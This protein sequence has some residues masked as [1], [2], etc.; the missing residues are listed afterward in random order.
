MILKRERFLLGMLLL[1]LMPACR[2]GTA[3]REKEAA[4]A[5]STFELAPGFTMEMMAIEPLISDPVAMEIDEYGR[6]YVVEMHG[7]PLDKSG[8]GKVKLLSDTDGDGKM[9]KSVVF[10][11][12]LVLPTGVLR[13]QKGILV[14]DAPNVLYFEDTDGDGRSD[15]RDTLLRGFALSNPQHNVNNPVLGM[16]NWIYL[17]H[18]PAITSKM[19]T[20]EFGDTGSDIY[21]PGRVNSPKLPQ[22]ARGRSVRFRPDRGGLELLSSFTQFGQTFDPWGR[23]LLVHN[24]NHIYHE[25]IGF[26]YLNRNPD[27]LVS[28]ATQS[29]SDHGAAAEVY[30][31]T[32]NPEHQIY[33]DVGVFTSSCGLTY[34]SGGLFPAPFDSVSFVAEPVSNIV[35]A[36]LLRDKGASFTASRL[37]EN[38]EFLAST[39]SWFRPVNMYVGPDGALYILDYYRQIIEHPEWMEDEVVKSGALYN[40]MDKGRIYRITP[41][42]TSSAS[43]T[44]GFKLGD[45]SSEQLVEKLADPNGWYRRN[46]QRLLIDR[47]DKMVVPQLERMAENPGSPLGRLHALWTLEGMNTLSASMIKKALKDPVAGIRENVVRLSELYLAGEQDMLSALLVMKDDPDAKVRFQL[48]CTLGFSDAPQSANIIQHLLFKDIDDEWVQIAA[49][50]ALSSRGT[51]LL[52][53]VLNRYQPGNTAYASLIERLSAMA[54]AGGNI[55]MVK[56][57]IQNALR[58]VAKNKA[59]WQAPV[60]K[61]I[62]WGLRN[63]KVG[64][65]S[66]QKEQEA[67]LQAA[68]GNE[69]FVSRG[70]LEI[71]KVIGLPSGAGAKTA[72]ENAQRIAENP[73]MPEQKRTEAVDFLVFGKAET[74]IDLFKTLISPKEPLPVQL[75]ALRSLGK[76]TDPSVGAFLLEKW[77]SLTGDLRDAA[78]SALITSEDRAALL[79]DALENN[80]VEQSAIPWGMRVQLMAQANE[81][82]RDRARNLFTKEDKQNQAIIEQYRSSLTLKGGEKNGKEVF[83]KNCSVC[84]QIGER[85]GAPYGPDLGTIRNRRSESILADILNPN[86]SIADGYDIWIIELNSGEN[87]QGLIAT[88]TPTAI[89]VRMYGGTEMAIA[90]KEIRSLKALGMS[91]MPAGLEKQIS[92][93][94]MADLLAYIR[95]P[96]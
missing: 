42:G 95:Q 7:Y 30:P 86:L 46:A 74:Y 56:S 57:L 79:L 17:G 36:D 44:K 3:D 25:V 24:A 15:I 64:A 39:D 85:G 62:A 87:I 48:L 23:H 75:A 80:K 83:I 72:L 40:G 8:S 73:G 96:K 27:L 76:I 50:S 9:D 78:I 63:G 81:S 91:A 71:L 45:A 90:R 6:M 32:Q 89:T 38:K 77:P 11:D 35:H 69:S 82:L 47:Q 60:L 22:N 34:Y 14:T 58:P 29:I 19:Y 2:T 20:E 10:A 37:Y 31:I 53:A 1:F 51:G 66:L 94:Q 13:W 16:D 33:T 49:L 43:W 21:Y 68:L 88:E 5:L 55:E 59:G 26:P 61:G 18:E 93:Q 12:K 41:E 28:D 67:L 52:Q 92:Q 84:H 54:A 70:S 65:S 4:L